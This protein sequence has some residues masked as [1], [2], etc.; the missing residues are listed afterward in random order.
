MKK[1][2]IVLY[3]NNL[4]GISVL[5]YIFNKRII[6]ISLIVLSKKN[7]NKNIIKEISKKK[8]PYKITTNVNAK[9]NLNFIKKM[10]LI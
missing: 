6:N 8:I 7:L 9:N 3:F 5:N 4:R 10:I 1:I 2:N